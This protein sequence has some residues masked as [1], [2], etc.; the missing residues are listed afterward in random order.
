MPKN[1]KSFLK[2]FISAK[3]EFVS[4]KSHFRYHVYLYAKKGGTVFNGCKYCNDRL[5]NVDGE[6]RA[7]K[8]END[9]E[10]DKEYLNS[11]KK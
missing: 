10:K 11:D 6:S 3:D 1:K 4:M 9:G 7:Y 2:N 5:V 8:N